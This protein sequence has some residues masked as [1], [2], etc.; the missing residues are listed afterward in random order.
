M[1]GEYNGGV[2]AM[3]PVRDGGNSAARDW[4]R[5]KRFILFNAMLYLVLST[6]AVV[7]DIR[8]IMVL[9]IISGLFFVGAG[10]GF[11]LLMRLGNPLNPIAW[12]LI[13]AGIFFGAGA[14]VGALNQN[15]AIYA[16][17][18]QLINDILSVNLLNASSVLVVLWVATALFDRMKGSFSSRETSYDR[19]GRVLLKYYKGM[20]SFTLVITLL[21]YYYFPIPDNLLVRSF[22]SYGTHAAHAFIMV[23]SYLWPQLRK[24]Q[25]WLGLVVFA[26]MLALNLLSYSKMASTLPLVFVVVGVWLRNASPKR[27]VIGVIVL[28]TYYVNISDVMTAARASPFYDPERNTLNERLV[29]LQKSVDEVF[30]ARDEFHQYQKGADELELAKYS[31]FSTLYIQGFL[32]QQYQHGMPGQSLNDFWAALIP[33]AFWPDKPNITRFGNELYILY[34]N[35]IGQTS[36]APSYTGEA[37]WNYG[38]A[39]L[40][41]VSLVLGLEI[42][43]LAH[44]ASLAMMGKDPAYFVIA[45]PGILL[46]VN[47][48]SWIAASYLGGFVTLLVLYFIAKFVLR[49]MSRKT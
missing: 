30:F 6:W 27:I 9:H 45:L 4:R 10:V 33:R 2:Q 31:R 5:S 36:L 28:V 21:N 39:G 48:E 1:R 42:G 29:L 34:T 32:I 49:R 14:V 37:F 38:P 7:A 18:E 22:M 8:E 35:Q 19:V 12:Y 23:L 13:G 26:L 41:I 40:I 3:S 44:H 24:E 46:A 11:Y 17:Q 43:W 15:I 20:L 25:A 16:S 47:M